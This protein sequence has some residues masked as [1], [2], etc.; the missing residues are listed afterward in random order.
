L[1]RQCG[2]ATRATRVR[3]YTRVA[4]ASAAHSAQCESTSARRRAF[5][6][7]QLT[8]HLCAAC[9]QRRRPVSSRKPRRAAPRP[10]AGGGGRRA[11]FEQLEDVAPRGLLCD[12]A[13]RSLVRACDGGFTAFVAACALRLSG[14]THPA[15]ARTRD[16]CAKAC[17]RRP[18]AL[19]LASHSA[20]QWR[21]PS[22]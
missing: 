18:G 3:P 13:R 6:G 4:A 10:R 9:L 19:L 8:L 17:T 2:A 12:L 5:L 14:A 15:H 7:R 16:C 21:A 11:R 22:R 1:W 20:L